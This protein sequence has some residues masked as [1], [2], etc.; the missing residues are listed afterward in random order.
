MPILEA[1][2]I[3]V[4][5]LLVMLTT[6]TFLDS[7]CRIF[8]YCK[9]TLFPLFICYSL[10]TRHLLKEKRFKLHLLVNGVRTFEILKNIVRFTPSL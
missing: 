7:V 10:D 8:F 4:I 6:T 3:N 5:S 1:Y 9:A 2:D